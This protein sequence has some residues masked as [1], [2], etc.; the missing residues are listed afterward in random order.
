MTK[1]KTDIVPWEEMMANEAK[2]V[3]KTERPS[4]ARISLQSGVMTYQDTAVPDN[5]LDCIVAATIHEQVYYDKPFQQGIVNPPACFALGAV[6]SA[7]IAHETVPE[8]E[9]G[10]ECVT[11]EMN[12]WGSSTTG[13]GKGKA[14]GERRKLAI[15]PIFDT[16]E[17]YKLA[18]IAVMSLPVMSVRNW[19]TYVNQLSAQYQRPA[20]GMITRIKVV[21]DAKSQFKVTFEPGSLVAE[22]FMGVIHDRIEMCVNTLMVPYDMTPTEERETEESKKY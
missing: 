6:G 3:A 20:W 13:S 4:V 7:L 9:Y 22:D 16:P 15:L 14:C 18:E 1:A 11:C 21:P 17:E 5:T 12:A 2:D 10:R 8:R 19:R